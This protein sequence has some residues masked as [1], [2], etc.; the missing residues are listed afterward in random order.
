MMRA[1]RI[2]KG[3]NIAAD[4]GASWMDGRFLQTTFTA[5]RT[6]NDDKPDVN[7]AGF[8]GLSGLRS[9]GDTAF[10]LFVDGHTRSVSA[11]G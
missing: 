10:I 3:K 2:G 6:L 9:E 11:K 5:T 7:C 8:G 4:R 1:S